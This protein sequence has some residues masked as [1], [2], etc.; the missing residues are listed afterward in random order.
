MRARPLLALGALLSALALTPGS[1]SATGTAAQGSTGAVA[2]GEGRKLFL[3]G[4]T[5]TCATCH[6]LR[7]AGAT[8]AIGPDLDALKPDAAR[9]K[10][11]VQKGFENMPAFG[12]VLS[13]T[14]VDAL[15]RYVE[16]ATAAAK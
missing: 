3:S 11:A 13:A 6:A 4:T 12:H 16:Q 15:A 14:Q 5:P 1:A 9:V 2:A 7:D 8:G 10:N